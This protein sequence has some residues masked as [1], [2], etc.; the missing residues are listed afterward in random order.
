[1]G[2]Q[3]LKLIAHRALIAGPNS[4]LE[5]HPERV[6]FALMLGYDVE[7]DIRYIDGKW[8]LGHDKPEYEVPSDFIFK[9]GLWLH[10]KN[11]DALSVLSSCP[12]WLTATFN[13]MHYFWHQ[14][15]DYT[16]TSRAYVWTHVNNPYKFALPRSVLVM[17]EENGWSREEMK[18]AYGICSKNVE[19][20]KKDLQ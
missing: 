3:V 7:V 11:I 14:E 15:D 6:N 12:R 2:N 10:C 16:I 5:N 20:L 8:F 1:M 18:K 19:Q 9:D 13:P 17:P 4:G